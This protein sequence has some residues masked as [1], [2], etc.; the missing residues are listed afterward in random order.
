[1]IRN[2]NDI[3]Q[4]N[5]S[6][7]SEHEQDLNSTR[8]RT[9]SNLSEYDPDHE[10]EQKQQHAIFTNMSYEHDIEQEEEQQ[11]QK[12]IKLINIPEHIHGSLMNSTNPYSTIQANTSMKKNN[13][14]IDDSTNNN[15]NRNK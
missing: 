2:N 6:D 3:I 5:R 8:L 1:M 15:R 10:K 12:H 9:P 7:V 14:S 11:Q 4:I 13:S